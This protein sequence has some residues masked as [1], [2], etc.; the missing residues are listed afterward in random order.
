MSAVFILI[1]S[2][3]AFASFAVSQWRAIWIAAANQPLSD[4]LPLSAGISEETLAEHGFGSLLELS[5]KLCPGMKKSTPWLREVSL[6]HSLL[7]GLQQALK[8]GIPSVANWATQEMRTCSRYVAVALSQN[9]TM[10]MERQLVTT[11]NR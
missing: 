7:A 1:V 4:S 10:Q 9:L 6:Y 8:L 11:A 3:L 2:C 5:E